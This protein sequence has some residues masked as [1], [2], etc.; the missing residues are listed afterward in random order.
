MKRH[1][2]CWK[3]WARAF[4]TLLLSAIV[5]AS[6]ILHFVDPTHIENLGL[7]R[8]AA[9]LIGSIELLAVA[10]L[11]TMQRTEL[12]E[13]T[14]STILLGAIGLYLKTGQFPLLILPVVPLALVAV[15]HW[16]NRPTMTCACGLRHHAE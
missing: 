11:W 8:V 9:Y 7:P 2:S 12:A 14:I 16:L 15:V 10:G 6:A 1:L 5:V 13:V 3:C 4:S